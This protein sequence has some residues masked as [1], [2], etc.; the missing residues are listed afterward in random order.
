M[1]D[2]TTWD[3]L[4]AQAGDAVVE[5]YAPLPEN[6][7]N[8]EIVDAS[9][10]RTK[11][12]NKKMWKVQTKVIGGEFN[13]RRIFDQLVLSPEND[14]AV[15]IFFSQMNVLGLTRDY[16]KSNPTDEAIAA[17][18]KGRQF[19]AK[20]IQ[21]PY[22]GE[23]KNE[24]KR[25]IAPLAVAS[26]PGASAPPAP[27]APAAVAPPVAPPV[28]AAPP[29]PAPAAPAPAPVAEQ[30]VAPAPP[31]PAPAAPAPSP[32]AGVVPPA[33]PLENLPF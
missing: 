4:M 10:T 11:S 26:P 32:E 18:M 5:S 16:F 2:G 19:K 7:Y 23:V 22:Q 1:T 29:V 27:A 6:D 13:N 17:A 15:S 12:T 25:Y 9:F 8:L 30:P 24:I 21:K 28:A 33:P 31:A 14:T 3:E 20:V